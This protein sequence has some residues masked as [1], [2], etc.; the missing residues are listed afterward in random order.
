MND[1]E[2][3]W[4]INNLPYAVGTR[5]AAEQSLLRSPSSYPKPRK[6]GA[7]IDEIQSCVEFNQDYF[8]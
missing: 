5:H 4:P 2:L 3:D 7:T 1:K 8:H 6:H